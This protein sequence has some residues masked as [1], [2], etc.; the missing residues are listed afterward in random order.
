MATLLLLVTL[1]PTRALSRYIIMD[2]THINSKGSDFTNIIQFNIPLTS[3][4]SS[5]SIHTF[6]LYTSVLNHFNHFNGWIINSGLNASLWVHRYLDRGLLEI[7]GPYGLFK[8]FHYLA[9]E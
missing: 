5:S 2:Q 8:F 6:E 3:T 9:F 7:F 4:S 1:L